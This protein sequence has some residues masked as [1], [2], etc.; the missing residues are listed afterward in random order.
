MDKKTKGK[1]IMNVFREIQRFNTERGLID[2]YNES[3]EIMMAKEELDEMIHAETTCERIGELCDQIVVATGT[4]LKQGFDPEK[5]MAETLKKIFSRK[6]EID[7]FGK[8]RKDPDQD[9]STLYVPDYVA[10][11]RKEKD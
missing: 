5:A 1:K 8:W 6:G 11:L 7:S 3:N 9:R 4:I 2:H 10:C